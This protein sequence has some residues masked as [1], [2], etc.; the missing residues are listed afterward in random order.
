MGGHL[1]FLSWL[2]DGHAWAAYVILLL[3]AGTLIAP[4]MIVPLTISRTRGKR[5]QRQSVLAPAPERPP[6]A[7][8]EPD[9]SVWSGPSTSEMALAK[10]Q[11]EERERHRRSASAAPSWNPW[12]PQNGQGGT[13]PA[14]R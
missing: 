4:A 6:V 11:F 8:R 10:L 2:A 5:R 3:A 9:A 7:R 14:P 12:V 13:T 1:S